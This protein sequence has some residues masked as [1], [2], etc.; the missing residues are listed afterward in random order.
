MFIRR[1]A[2]HIHRDPGGHPGLWTLG[3]G[4]GRK[5]KISVSESQEDGRVGRGL[6]QNS[7]NTFTWNALALTVPPVA[8][9]N[10]AGVLILETV[11]QRRDTE[12]RSVSTGW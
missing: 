6:E 5:G 4:S 2:H 12:E 7:G 3:E 1:Q 8:E 11:T 9:E 10:L